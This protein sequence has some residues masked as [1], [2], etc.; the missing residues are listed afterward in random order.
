MKMIKAL[1]I[2]ISSLRPQHLLSNSW[3]ATRKRWARSKSS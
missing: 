2:S 3:G 1:T